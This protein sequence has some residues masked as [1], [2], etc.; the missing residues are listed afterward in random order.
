MLC[1]QTSSN[2][3]KR[4]C[5]RVSVWLWVLCG[6][7]DIKTAPFSLTGS[8]CTLTEPRDWWFSSQRCSS[9]LTVVCFIKCYRNNRKSS[10]VIHLTCCY[11]VYITEMWK[12]LEKLA[13][14]LTKDLLIWNPWLQC[15]WMR[16]RSQGDLICCFSVA[17]TYLWLWSTRG[18]M[19]FVITTAHS[20]IH[21]W[22]AN[23]FN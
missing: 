20:I 9:S 6:G 11:H 21:Y 15:L 8:S 18:I 14:G 1:P 19:I 10:T 16:G 12:I 4:T 23:S 3:H 2:L 13:S 17:M 5:I 22:R 7:K